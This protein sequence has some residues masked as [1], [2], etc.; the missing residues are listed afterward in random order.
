MTRTMLSESNQAKSARTP[1]NLCVVAL[2]QRSSCHCP[3]Q[4]VIAPCATCSSHM[5]SRLIGS[6]QA[7]HEIGLQFPGNASKA[8]RSRFPELWHLRVFPDCFKDL[9]RQANAE[10]DSFAARKEMFQ[11]R[12]RMFAHLLAASKSDQEPHGKLKFHEPGTPCAMAAIQMPK[13]VRQERARKLRLQT[14][15]PTPD[16][17]T[18]VFSGKPAAVLFW[19]VRA[20]RSATRA[21]KLLLRLRSD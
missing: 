20:T 2:G 8:P 15:G 11:P 12:R 10:K 3:C 4:F 18:L 21:G 13:S 5:H 14:A 1:A 7:I 19:G 9:N 17:Q 16:S 6:I